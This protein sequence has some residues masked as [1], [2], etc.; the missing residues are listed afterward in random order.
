MLA[1][2]GCLNR[3][4]DFM[5]RRICLDKQSQYAPQTPYRAEITP[6][7]P[8][9]SASCFFALKTCVCVA[10]LCIFA[11]ITQKKLKKCLRSVD[12]FGSDMY[13][14]ECRIVLPRRRFLRFPQKAHLGFRQGGLMKHTKTIICFLRV[15]LLLVL[16]SSRAS[17]PPCFC[18]GAF[19]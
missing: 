6:S 7:T 19:Q 12:I 15:L 13:N 8:N 11:C 3:K 4:G 17:A 18:V 16:N 10:K 1:K 2:C 9:D 5:R 14:I